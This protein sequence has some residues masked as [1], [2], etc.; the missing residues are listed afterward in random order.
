MESDH[1]AF[2]DCQ[3]DQQLIDDVYFNWASATALPRDEGDLHPENIIY[4]LQSL[5][6]PTLIGVCDQVQL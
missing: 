5:S 4:S 1:D 3:E 2:R 6:D